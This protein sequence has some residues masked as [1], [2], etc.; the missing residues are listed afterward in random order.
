MKPLRTPPALDPR[1]RYIVA[2]L[3]II[4]LVAATGRA[5]GWF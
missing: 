1:T 4:G 3:L 2:A 5:L